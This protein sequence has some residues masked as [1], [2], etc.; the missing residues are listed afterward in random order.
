LVCN[1]RKYLTTCFEAFLYGGFIGSLYYGEVIE[2]RGRRYAVLESL[3]MMVAGLGVSLLSGS[4]W[5]F[6]LGVFFFNAG[7]RGFYNASLLSIAE[8]TNRVMRA[9]TPMILSI[10]WAVGQIVIGL[11]S[12]VMISWRLIFFLTLLPLAGLLYYI[13]THLLD[14][15]RF[16]VTKHKFKE[17]KMA[18]ERMALANEKRP[19]GCLLKEQL[20]Y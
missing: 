3:V 4:A 13:N 19:V 16:L 20:E 11:L 9:T 2:R 10:G 6:S 5:L 18:V 12:M 15:P 14:S 1:R 17:A 7:F 8:V